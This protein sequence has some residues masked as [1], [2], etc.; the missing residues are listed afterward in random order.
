MRQQYAWRSMLLNGI[1]AIVAV[2]VI[3]QM[4]RIQA[5]AEAEAF[6]EQADAFKGGYRTYYPERGEIYDRNGHLLAGNQTVYEVGVD[7][8]TVIDPHSVAMAISVNLGKSYDEVFT[9]ILNPPPGISYLVVDNFA[10][11]EAVIH[12]K[13]LKKE[14]N[15]AEDRTPSLAGLEFSPRL[16]RSYPE[17]ALASNVIGFVNREGRGYFGVEEK[18]NDLLAG[19]PVRVWVP[20]DPNQAVEI[21]RVP[22]GTSLILTLNRDLQDAVE[23]ILDYSLNEYDAQHGTIIVMDPQ[24]GEILAMAATP[25]MNLNNFE[26][27]GAIFT[28]ASEYNRAIGMPYEPGSVTKIFTMAAA[29]DTG[30]VTPN[31][32]FL[33]TGEIQIGGVTIRNWDQKAWGVQNMVGCL[34][35]SLNVCLTWVAIQLGPQNFYGY[36]NRFGFGRLT[37][38]DM[39]GEAAGRLKIPGDADWYPVDLGTNSFGQGMSAT[40]LQIMTAASAIANQGRMVTPHTLYAMLRDGHQFNVPPQFAGSPIKTETAATLNEMLA[41]SLENEAS[42]ALVP[43]YRISGK[44]GTAQIPTPFGFYDFNQTNAS[45]VGWGPVDDP[46][47]MIYVW[48]ERPTASPWGS[49]TAAPV[50]SEV[51]Q[52]TVILLDIPPD[53]VRLNMAAR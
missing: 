23:E 16:K 25:R 29:L 21:P 22:N 51:A 4:V 13:E 10:S 14:L 49:Q 20:N 9:D 3:L 27:Y 11:S 34:Q 17:T 53:S 31:T 12:L 19:N 38:V 50:F 30:L 7:L 43:G 45:F 48:L 42:A 32:T 24:N 26:N 35:H 37:G 39:S 46:Q 2:L 6:R 40:P 41:V 5:S 15:E 52:K 8:S 1:M 47:F 18:Y 33:D 36:M 44:T 28:N